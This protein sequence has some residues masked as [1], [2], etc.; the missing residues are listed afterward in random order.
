MKSALSCA[1]A[2]ALALP[3]AAQTGSV[4][5]SVS[6]SVTDVVVTDSS[7]KPITDLAPAD[8]E[9][10]QD[11]RVQPITNFSFVRNPLPP[12]PPVLEHGQTPEPAIVPADAA[13]PPA[14]PAPLI[15]FIEHP[16]PTP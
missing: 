2:I 4:S 6:V 7:G 5:R 13:P 9:I 10:R 1:G 16:P 11:G 8:F 3:L 14:A 12:P 15:L